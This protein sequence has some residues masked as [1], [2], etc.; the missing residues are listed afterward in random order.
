M[1]DVRARR[2][3]SAIPQAERVLRATVLRRGGLQR[4][5]QARYAIEFGLGDRL[6][7]MST[8]YPHHDS[9]FPNGV[10][11]FLNHTGISDEQKRKI[12]WDNGARVFGLAAAREA[13]VIA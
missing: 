10:D 13:L 1:G 12:L 7:L 8:D 4:G 11:M 3:L 6:L 5:H 2:R 9:P